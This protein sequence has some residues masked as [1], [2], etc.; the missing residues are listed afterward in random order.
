MEKIKIEQ[1]DM[2][3]RFKKNSLPIPLKFKVEDKDQTIITISINRILSMEK[4]N[5][6]GEDLYVYQCTSI[7]NRETI[8]FVLKYVLSE[9]KWYLFYDY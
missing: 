5:R 2:I 4:Q 9:T 6:G 1:P 8:K 7:V 3:V